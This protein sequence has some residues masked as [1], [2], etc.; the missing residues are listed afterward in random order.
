MCTARAIRFVRIR[1]HSPARATTTNTHTLMLLAPPKLTVTPISPTA[2]ADPKP[3]F[4]VTGVV[5]GLL[6]LWVLYVLLKAETRKPAPPSTP[7][8][9]GDGAE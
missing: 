1:F 9:S 3:L 6:A 7:S 4:W 5:L 2:T 8:A